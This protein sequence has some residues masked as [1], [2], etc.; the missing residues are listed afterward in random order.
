MSTPVE[1]AETETALARRY[2]LELNM[3]TTAAPVW[4]I[5]P[6][7][8]EFDPSVEPTTQKSATYE[9]EGWDD[10]TVTELAWTIETTLLHR[11]HPE[12]KAFNPA[13]EKLRLAGESFGT[14]S[15]VHVRW[16]DRE[17]RDEAYEGRALVQWDPD[18]GATDDL[19]SIGVTLTGKGAKTKI[20]N[21]LA[22]GG[23]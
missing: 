23:A 18:G 16:Y 2:R 8:Q 10:N 1:P 19:D 20:T 13:Q 7:V 11:C 14:T 6:G 17:A 4:A 12:T 5:V 3:G 9:D 22:G 21:P 15:A